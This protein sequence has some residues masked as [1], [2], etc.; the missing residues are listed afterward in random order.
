MV[1]G[2]NQRLQLWVTYKKVENPCESRELQVTQKISQKFFKSY[3]KFY[4]L[5]N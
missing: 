2:N 1:R 3:F 5:G 4:F